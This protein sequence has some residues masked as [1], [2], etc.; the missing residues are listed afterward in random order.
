MGFYT[1]QSL[2]IKLSV[3]AEAKSNVK[4]SYSY[5]Y[6]IVCLTTILVVK[7]TIDIYLLYK[8]FTIRIEG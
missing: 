3:A 5:F 2:L 6:S 1:C 8:E 4:M 7:H